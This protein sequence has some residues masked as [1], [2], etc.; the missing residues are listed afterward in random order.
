MTLLRNSARFPAAL[1]AAAVLAFVRPSAADE[2]ADTGDNC[3]LSIDGERRDIDAAYAVVVTRGEPAY[4]RALGWEAAALASGTTWYWLD[5]E[6]QVAD[7]DYPSIEDRLTFAAW[8]YDNNSFPINFIWHAFNG[9]AFHLV[10]RVN[11]LSLAE[12]A[13]YGFLTSM[14]WEYGLEFREK[15]SINDVLTTPGA[16]IPIAEFAYWLG[17]YVNSAPDR[18][19]T[20]HNVA[21]WAFGWPQAMHLAW[22]ERVEALVGTPTDALG[23]SA[24]I[25]HQFRISYG[26]GAGEVEVDEVLG[27]DETLRMHELRFDGRL[28]AMPGFLRPGRFRKFF[29]DANKTDL[30]FRL[31]VTG[32]GDGTG[33]ELLADTMILGVHAQD[34]PEDGVGRAITIGANLS[35]HYRR[36]NFGDWEDRLGIL[37]LPGV[38]ADG[39]LVGARW[40]LRLYGRLNGDFAGIHGTAYPQWKTVNP[41]TV[42]KSIL[43]KQGYYYGW[44]WSTRWVTELSLPRVALGGALFYG[45]YYSDEGLDRAQEL[46][47]AD[48]RSND[49]V[50]DG[51]GW[52]RVHP[53]GGRLYLEARVTH[54]LRR[55]VLEQYR[56]DQDLTRYQLQFGAEL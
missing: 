7:W 47:F 55:S 4:W 44:G 45:R 21:R 25:W 27:E 37:H 11:N 17:R 42:E 15:V 1:A 54:Q 48:L 26:A 51:E 50:I 33:T 28:F 34:I 14:V 39:Y 41:N 35:Y 49:K 43:R 20:R 10:G 6:R 46:V 40:R 32:D 38:A 18:S 29:R 53:F 5:R 30:M 22:D 12:S 31:T 24:D 16:G 56:A 3:F 13:G 8:R 23:L 52:L 36:E 9:S 19:K 2:C